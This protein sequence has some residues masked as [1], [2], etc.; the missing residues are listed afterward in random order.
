MNNINLI[1]PWIRRFLMEHLIQERNLASNTQ[2]SY[3]DAIV[4]LVSFISK[5]SKR[6]IDNLSIEDFSPK[7]IRSFLLYLEKDRR[8]SVATR[9]QRLATIHALA[10]FIA[11]H[12]PQYLAWCNEIYAIPFKK[13]SKPMICYLEKSEMDALLNIPDRDR[14]QGFRDYALLLFL[15]N[16]GARADEAAQLT[17]GNLSLNGSSSVKIV[18]KGEKERRCPLWALTSNLLSSLIDGRT[19]N[20]RVFLNRRKQ[21][22]TRFGLYSLVKRYAFKASQQV[23]SLSKKE[24]TPHVIRH[25]CATHLLRAGVDI[26]TIRAYLGH[27]S[28]DTTLAYT[29]VDL[30]MKTK[31]ASHCEIMTPISSNK[32]Q[33][34]NRKLM[35][36]LKAI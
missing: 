16:T 4:L 18:G 14:M 17:I 26:N 24:V 22:M 34:H 27:V 2:K 36:F 12:N 32:K 7:A 8:C 20:E 25:T 5:N 21:P 35:N 31:A 13:T 1:G 28:L 30:E 33:W 3:R 29:E 10:Y 9:N 6:L 23:D 15:Y 19:P 11:M